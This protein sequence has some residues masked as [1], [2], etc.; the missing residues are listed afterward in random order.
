MGIN[1]CTFTKTG[2]P[3]YRARK[4]ESELWIEKTKVLVLVNQN[5]GSLRLGLVWSKKNL[6]L[7]FE[8]MG[9]DL[10]KKFNA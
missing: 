1:S 3:F 7:Y 8:N 5:Q 2:F 6:F 10:A 4:W 9:L